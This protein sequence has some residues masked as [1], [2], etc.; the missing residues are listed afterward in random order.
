MKKKLLH[1]FFASLTGI[2]FAVVY[3][4]I[5]YEIYTI[6]TQMGGKFLAKFVPIP[7]AL[8]MLVFYSFH[9]RWAKRLFFYGI[10]MFTAFVF[11]VL[12]SPN[13]CQEVF[14]QYS[15]IGKQEQA[16]SFLSLADTTRVTANT[17]FSLLSP[18]E[19]Y[20]IKQCLLNEN[21]ELVVLYT[22]KHYVENPF[23]ISRKLVGSES[24]ETPPYMVV[25]DTIGKVKYSVFWTQPEK[26]LWGEFLLKGNYIIDLSTYEYANYTYDGSFIMQPMEYLKGYDPAHRETRAP[27]S[28]YETF[29]SDEGE[30]GG[31]PAII[32]IFIEDDQAYYFF[33]PTSEKNTQYRDDQDENM[34]ISNLFSILEE[35]EEKGAHSFERRNIL[36]QDF[37]YE[38]LTMNG[39]FRNDQGEN[40]EV[41]YS[42]IQ[43]LFDLKIGKDTFHF[44]KE[45]VSNYKGYNQL[46]TPTYYI[47]NEEETLE[48]YK[49]MFLYTNKHLSYAI[50]YDGEY[51]YMVK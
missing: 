8:G 13:I 3:A 43:L 47:E 32:G 9:Y 24:F 49:D 42:D 21:H 44:K 22:E 17:R 11:F 38:S 20:Q 4:F 26:E 10:E 5:V 33:P 14:L 18:K 36:P 50:F 27:I 31:Y 1:L 6:V 19:G 35:E 46:K 51:V 30:C 2:A 37:Y 40:C 12:Y 39:F 29:L 41:T 45:K 34:L 15:R 25:Y 7:F 23:Y 48:K 16:R 28:Y